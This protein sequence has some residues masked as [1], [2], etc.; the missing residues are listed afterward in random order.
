MSSQCLA[1]SSAVDW[2]I[3][4]AAPRMC[5][6]TRDPATSRSAPRGPHALVHD[7]VSTRPPDVR[8]GKAVRRPYLL[9]PAWAA[10]APP[11]PRKPATRH[12]QPHRVHQ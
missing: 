5:R 4:N 12:V 2:L 6:P 9:H 1:A 3:T 7:T 8:Y 10:Q 11:Q